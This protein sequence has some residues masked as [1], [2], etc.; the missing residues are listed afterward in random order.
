MADYPAPVFHTDFP[1]YDGFHLPDALLGSPT[2]PALV[3]PTVS[4]G[5]NTLVPTMKSQAGV[6]AIW[7]RNHGSTRVSTSFGTFDQ[8]F[9][10]ANTA[11]ACP[12]TY[13]FAP[14]AETSYF[15]VDLLQADRLY[16]LK[17]ELFAAG[18]VTPLETWF[19][20]K[21]NRTLVNGRNAP[22]TSWDGRVRAVLA[23][24][25]VTAARSPYKLKVT[26]MGLHGGEPVR[27]PIAWTYFAVLAH[28]IEL[29]WGKRTR[30]EHAAVLDRL[31]KDAPHPGAIAEHA[32][33]LGSNFFAQSVDDMHCTTGREDPR[34]SAHAEAWGEG[35]YIP[36]IAR[37]PVRLSTSGQGGQDCVFVPQALG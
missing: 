37:V 23:G 4:S 2:R 28:T 9:E 32:V 12:I 26:A 1:D 3:R 27:Y 15:D 16:G 19:F 11:Q 36:M 24:G 30:P 13:W 33:V 29:A 14:L 22:I 18:E 21:T 10:P 7:I 35:P 31:K 17:V 20:G 25:V 5:L 34:F 8:H 6:A